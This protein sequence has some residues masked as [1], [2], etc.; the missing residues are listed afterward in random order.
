MAIDQMML[1]DYLK[2]V[3]GERSFVK[4]KEGDE[5]EARKVSAFQLQDKAGCVHSSS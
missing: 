3:L 1:K 5:R 4:F 2:N